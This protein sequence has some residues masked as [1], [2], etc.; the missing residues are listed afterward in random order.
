MSVSMSVKIQNNNDGKKI[1]FGTLLHAVAKM[2]NS[3][4]VLWMIQ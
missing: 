4:Q 3:W 2:V 1:I